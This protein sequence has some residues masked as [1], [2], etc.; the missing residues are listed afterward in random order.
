MSGTAGTHSSYDK[1]LTKE[2]VGSI[3]KL[4]ELGETSHQWPKQRK[5]RQDVF[6]NE[7]KVFNF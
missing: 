1:E 3:Q 5:E 2:S 7:S 4:R 6:R